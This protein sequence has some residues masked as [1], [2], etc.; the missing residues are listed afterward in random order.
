MDCVYNTYA[1]FTRRLF[2]Q[3]SDTDDGHPAATEQS[4]L[5]RLPPELRLEICSYMTIAPAKIDWEWKGAFFSC[6]QLHKDMLDRLP[7]TQEMVRFLDTEVELPQHIDQ[8]YRILPGPPHPFFGWIRSL[9]IHIP[10]SEDWTEVMRQLYPLCLDEL[11]VLLIDDE[12][13]RH[14]RIS[15]P[16]GDLKSTV[17]PLLMTKKPFGEE[18]VMNCKKITVTLHLLNKVEGARHKETSFEV[19]L[20]DTDINYLFTIVEDK[21]ERQVERSYTFN[22]R[23]RLRVE[24][25]RTAPPIAWA[26]SSS[27]LRWF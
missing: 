24:K 16:Y 18:L 2:Q 14:H 22:D 27:R 25:K 13:L 9:T 10:L 20:P 1:A 23:F 19:T 7:P 21:D 8:P 15:L 17:P 3:K 11:K 4:P 5:L 6:T 26:S 12:G